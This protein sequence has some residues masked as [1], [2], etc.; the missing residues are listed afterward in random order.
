[1]KK[2]YYIQSL[3]R[4]FNQRLETSKWVCD[5]VF[6]RKDK[7]MLSDFNLDFY[8]YLIKKLQKKYNS[9]VQIEYSG[10]PSKVSVNNAYNYI[11]GK[12][13][14]VLYTQI[15]NIIRDRK[16]GFDRQIY[17]TYKA[18]SYFINL[19]KEKFDLLDEKN[20]LTKSGLHLVKF[21]SPFFKLS[22][23]EKE[24]FFLKILQADFHFF[25][26]ICYF[27]R[28]EKKYKIKGISKEQYEFLDDFYDIRHFNFTSSSLGN[29]NKVRLSWIEQL[30]LLDSNRNIRKKYKLLIQKSNF[31]ELFIELT[32]SLKEYEVR[33]FKSKIKYIRK[34]GKFIEQYERLINEDKGNIGFVNL[35][36]IK[37]EMNMSYQNFQFFLERFHEEEMNNY[38]IFY[39]NIVNSIDKRKRF[40]IRKKPVINIK[41]K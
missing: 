38:N 5:F 16:T 19:A 10:L 29:F 40:Y 11:N 1:M 15:R 32:G 17:S 3:H 37:S 12:S 41:V 28:L 6:K 25:I 4:P 14:N 34:K 39:N 24:F 20:E 36:D 2:L 23:Q 21:R 18:V 9:N 30:D 35:Y 13:K 22:N 7:G 27:L 33:K 26:S 31:Y 8:V